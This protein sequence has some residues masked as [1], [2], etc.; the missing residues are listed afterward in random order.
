MLI[1]GYCRISTPKQSIDRQVTNIKKAYPDAII[2]QEVYSGTKSDRPEFVK[3][4]KKV[5][6]GDTIVF[7][8]VS[9]M[10]RNAD[11]G[12]ETY[13][14]LYDKGIELVF[15]KEQ[16]I[17]TAVYKTT[18][19][20]QLDT[21]ETGDKN[22]NELLDGIMTSLEKYMKALA[23]E[24]IRLAF[25]QAEK[26]VTDL[27]QRTAEG[28]REARAN[29]KQ[30][31]R[32]EGVKVTTKKEKQA[33]ELIRQ[34]NKAFDGELNDVETMAMLRGQGLSLARNTYYKY[35]RALTK[36]E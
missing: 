18:L 3:L 31:G 15:L 35:K 11:E 21:I 13:M 28:I 20:S 10:S 9:R 19:K 7:D 26:E 25:E 5:K 8:S 17:N 30:I 6:A 4:L 24:Q 29:G 2:M 34:Y 14:Q 23:R 36:K 12:F 1:Y 27:H 16:T 22:V 33:I 32:T